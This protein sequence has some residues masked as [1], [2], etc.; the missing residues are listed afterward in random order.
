MK[1]DMKKMALGVGLSTLA[2]M[3]IG[4]LWYGQIFGQQWL[5]LSGVTPE[6]AGDATTA[7]LGALVCA[8]LK[9]ATL[10]CFAH[11]LKVKSVVSGIMLGVTIWAGFVVTT[12]VSGVLFE[13]YNT[14]L[15][16]LHTGYDLATY[17]AIGAITALFV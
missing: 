10:Y 3:I 4:M 2:T 16:V 9:S 17:V 5:A 15:F 1:K 6:S 8:V 7:M 13:G 12:S 14:T 11:R